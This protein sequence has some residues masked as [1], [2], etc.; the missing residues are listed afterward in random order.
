MTDV[1]ASTFK[2][3]WIDVCAAAKERAEQSNF[4]FRRRPI[5]DYPA[6]RSVERELLEHHG[7]A[8]R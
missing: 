2:A 4:C 8:H 1:G 6:S 3:A 7:P 5:I